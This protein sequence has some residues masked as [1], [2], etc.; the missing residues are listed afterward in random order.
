MTVVPLVLALCTNRT[1][2][3]GEKCFAQMCVN[4]K[5]RTDFVDAAETYL[6]VKH[7]QTFPLIKYA[8]G[9]FV[10]KIKACNILM[11]SENNIII[12]KT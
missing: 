8:I 10:Y 5:N 7:P 3:Q 12:Y 2:L 6:L 11:F 1:F 9:N 4:V